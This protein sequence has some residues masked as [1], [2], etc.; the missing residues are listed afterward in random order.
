[1]LCFFQVE[2]AMIRSLKMKTPRVW[3]QRVQ[4]QHII[5]DSIL[6]IP[7]IFV[8]MLYVYMFLINDKSVLKLYCFLYSENTTWTDDFIAYIYQ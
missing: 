8:F 7:Q 4:F 5:Q 1:M 6:F 2:D 3:D